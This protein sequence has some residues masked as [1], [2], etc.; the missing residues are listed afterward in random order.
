MGELI[1]QV[2]L[3]AVV[4]CRI[5]RRSLVRLSEVFEVVV[6]QGLPC[7]QSIVHVVNQKLAYNINGVCGT[8]RD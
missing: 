7:R 1:L 8:I 4:C 5:G 2:D 6:F 3:Q